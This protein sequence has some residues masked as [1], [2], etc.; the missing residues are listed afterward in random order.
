MR[1]TIYT[2]LFL[3]SF[4]FF[5]G[6]TQCQCCEE[7]HRQFDF[8]VGNWVVKDTLGNKVGEN[9]ISKVEA[10]CV[11]ME[12][13]KGTGGTTGMSMNYYDRLDNTWNQVWIDSQGNI[14][15]LK[16]IFDSG[17]MILKSDLIKREQQKYYNQIV[18]S[19]NDDRTVTQLWE[20]R[21]SNG[22]HLKTLFK[23][24]YSRIS[25]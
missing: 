24:I 18:W 12:K 5:W 23:G 10:N 17:K 7:N 16:G 11:V 1:T 20:T 3:V 21:D 8:W 13:W 19:P 9:T 15:K 14:L 2:T 4:H 6:Q 25:N 22:R